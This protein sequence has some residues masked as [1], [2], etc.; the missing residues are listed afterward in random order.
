MMNQTDPI[1][2]YIADLWTQYLEPEAK[3]SFSKFGYYSQNLKVKGKVYDKVRLI[4]INTEPCYVFN[5][6]LW[7]NH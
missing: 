1:L 7:R 4:A 3:E 6:F 2:P 5:F